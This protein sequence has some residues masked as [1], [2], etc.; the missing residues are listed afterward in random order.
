VLERALLMLAV[1]ESPPFEVLE[2][3]WGEF[4]IGITIEFHDS[5]FKPV[6]KHLDCVV[7]VCV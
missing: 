7:F 2:H 5:S 3:G 4:A 1:I 6:L